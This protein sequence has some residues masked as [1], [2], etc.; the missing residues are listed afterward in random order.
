MV[1]ERWIF[2]SLLTFL[3]S[4]VPS[5]PDLRTGNNKKYEMEDAVLSAFAPLFVQCPSFLSYQLLMEKSKGK[6]NGRS[7]FGIDVIPSDNHIRNLLDPIA[8]SYFYPVFNDAFHFLEDTKIID[9]YR[10]A[11]DTN[12]IALD[13]TWFH[14][15]EK[16]YCDHCLHKDHKDGRKTYFHSVIT[17]VIV[18]PGSNKVISLEPEFI[19]NRDGN[20]KQDCENSAAK[21]WLKENGL[22]YIEK[23][24]TFLGDDLYCKQPLCELILSLGGNFIFTCKESSHKHLYEEINS[25][26]PKEDLN[27]IIIKKW[28][29][30]ERLYYRY[31]FMNN[32][33]LKDDE[34]AI[35]VNWVELTILDKDGNVR[36]RFAFATNHTITKNN[37][38]Y[39]VEAGR[40]RWKIENEHNNTL[41]TKGYNLEHNFGHGKENLS[42]LLLT[43]NLLAFLFHTILEFLDKRYALIRKTLPRRTTFYDDLR[44]LTRYFYFRHWKHLMHFMLE[45]LELEDP[46][47]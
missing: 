8:P 7:L 17:P 13:A 16:I 20:E 25:F 33:P 21:R 43:L 39:I 15:S 10:S 41:K 18:K 9:S 29:K 11:F 24:A 35:N 6:N 42:N 37:V 32:I 19:Q 1:E 22:K 26:D 2:N 28:V 3:K 4:V 40:S 45:G 27:E 36:K 38:V 47:G 31:R 23:G 12:L 44:A 46:G 14:S 34:K 5:L 30:K